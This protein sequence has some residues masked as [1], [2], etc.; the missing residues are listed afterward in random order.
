MLLD[1]A[2]LGPP[3][4]AYVAVVG[5]CGGMGRALVDALIQTQVHVAVLDLPSSIQ[6]YPPPSGAMVLPMDGGNEA[7][8]ADVFETLAQQWPRLDGLA[9]LA[10]FFKG[11]SPLGDLDVSVFDEVVAGNLRS[12][13]LCARAAIP[14]LQRS[15]MG[16]MVS[17]ASTQAVDVI[18]N[19]THYAA[20]KAGVVA[21]VKGMA[22]ENAP[23]IRCNALAPGLTDTPF[24]VGG[25][26]REQIFEGINPA[27]YAPKVP[28]NRMATASDMTGPI[29]FL[30][31]PASGFINGETL[32]VD[33]G[34][35]VQ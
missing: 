13:F 10:G 2:R 19:Y 27:R 1:P 29:L 14:L 21:M 25:T 4:G 11:L 17:V 35:Y 28:M 16:A 22:R 9:N 12:H 7:Q 6:Q 31:G 3:S 20:A 32:I 5:G 24:L 26:G 15:E 23:H 8:V 33:G 30:L 34:V 18:P